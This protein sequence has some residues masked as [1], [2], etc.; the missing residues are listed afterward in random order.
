MP[1]FRVLIHGID[2]DTHDDSTESTRPLG[3]YVT[4]FIESGTREEAESDA[5]TVLRSA[6]QLSS[7][8]LNPPN[9]PPKVFIEE[10]VEIPDWPR[11][12]T[13]PLTGFAF[14]DESDPDA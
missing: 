3:F 8:I 4:A 12:C 1:K 13:R 6:P 2:F 5:I 14:Y 7:T 11:N 10:L 9:K